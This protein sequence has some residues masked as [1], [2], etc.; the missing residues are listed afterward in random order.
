MLFIHSCSFPSSVTNKHFRRPSDKTDLELELR[1]HWIILLW[2][3]PDPPIE[4]QY[5]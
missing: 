3:A 5:C 2:H 1:Q 4:I